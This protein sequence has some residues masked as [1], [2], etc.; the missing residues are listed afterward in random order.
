M[1][2]TFLAVILILI[3]AGLMFREQ[4]AALIIPLTTPVENS[5]PFQKEFAGIKINFRANLDE[6]QKI[7]VYP[8]E[9]GL[10]FTLLDNNVKEI[11]IA[12]I[13][14]DTE[15]AFYAAAS[16]ELTFKLTVINKYYFDQVKYIDSIPVNSTEE[17][18]NIS[19]NTR[20][21]IM[22]LGP[23]NANS[24]S[25][26]VNGYLIIAQGKSF[27]ETNEKPY[28]DLDLAVDKILLVLMNTS[29]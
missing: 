21:I 2:E 26:N 18:F 27:G 29:I 22:L 28:T 13:P 3:I 19:N 12:Y 24:T 15:N 11:G 1:K 25:V 10:I 20:P 8:D 9:K 14:N 4:L 7:P 6:A 17:A 16:Y 5:N 23:S